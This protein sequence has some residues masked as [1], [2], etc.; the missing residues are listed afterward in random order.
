MSELVSVFLPTRNR[1]AL[2]VRC[3]DSVLAQTHRN[4]ELIIV[5]DASSDSTAETLDRYARADS[6]VRVISQESPRGAPAARNLA[7]HAARGTYATGIDDDDVM[8]PGRIAALVAEF[9]PAFSLVCSGFVRATKARRL[10]LAASRRLIDL[11]AQL[12]RNHVGNAALSLTSRFLE[13]GAFDETMPAWQ[14]YD[15]WTRM[16][17]RFG[18][19]LR[20]AEASHIVHEDHDSPRIST[21]T[22]QGAAR[23]RDKHR[24]LMTDRHLR[25]QRLEYFMLGGERMSWADFR[26][27][28]RP[29]MRARA[30]RYFVT[31]NFP[32]LR[33]IRRD[34]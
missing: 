2:L 26:Q 4:L 21:N 32:G 19:A 7:L 13:V 11:D 9:D 3:I 23:F 28:G 1:A 6:R 30:L 34:F 31:S 22:L 15:L 18:P 12:M 25:S 33:A 27:L 14:D 17:A 8:L 29:G 10:T 24:A 20:V 16:I 5:D